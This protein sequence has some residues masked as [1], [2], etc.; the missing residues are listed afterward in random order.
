M[1][2]D[3]GVFFSGLSKCFDRENNQ[4]EEEGET[5]SATRLSSPNAVRCTVWNGIIPLLVVATPRGGTSKSGRG[6]QVH[7]FWAP[8]SNLVSASLVAT[9]AS[10]TAATATATAT[11]T[12]AVSTTS[13]SAEI[14]GRDLWEVVLVLGKA[15]RGPGAPAPIVG[16]QTVNAAG[17]VEFARSWVTG[18]GMPHTIMGAEM[19]EGADVDIEVG[20]F[21]N[22][23]AKMGHS[24]DMADAALMGLTKSLFY[25]H[26]NFPFCSKCGVRT[27]PA[28]GGSK[29]ICNAC[30]SE[31]YPRTDPIAIILVTHPTFPNLCLLGRKATYTKDRFTCL[32]GYVEPGESLEEGACREVL[33]ESGIIVD[34]ANVH[35]HASQ[36]WPAL[37]GS[38]IM[39]GFYAKASSDTITVNTNE[40]EQIKWFPRDAVVQGVEAWENNT[41]NAPTGFGIPGPHTMAYCLLRDWVKGKMPALS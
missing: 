19:G 26:H 13:A 16:L 41:E 4:R 29:R 40:M 24:R 8:M 23:M 21:D 12:A 30:K 2:G 35:Y 18:G 11:G 34:T 17:A 7:L 36:P 15:I 33:E 25:F 27:I 10:A 20:F 3:G 22:W 28:H 5:F 32:A 1:D 39:A 6:P 37:A 38:Q 9:G 31:H 14:G